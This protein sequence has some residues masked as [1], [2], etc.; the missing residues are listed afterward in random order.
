LP[1]VGGAR[2]SNEQENSFLAELIIKFKNLS[3]GY[4][5][6]VTYI[7]PNDLNSNYEVIVEIVKGPFEHLNT[8][9]IIRPID[10]LKSEVIF[11]LDF[12][13]KSLIFEKM[14]GVLFEAATVKMT[15]AFEKRADEIS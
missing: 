11:E 12:K 14:I 1:W 2:I 6:K 13:F 10:E 4:T 8:H 3:H 9:W 7:E 5:S 15:K